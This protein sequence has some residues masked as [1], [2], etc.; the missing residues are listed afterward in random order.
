MASQHSGT[1]PDGID[2]FPEKIDIFIDGIDSFPDDIDT[3]P[4]RLNSFP[5]LLDCASV[6]NRLQ[7]NLEAIYAFN[8]HSLSLFGSVARNEATADSDLDFLVEFEGP[9]TFRGYMGLKFYLENLF[10]KPVDLVI[11]KDLKERIKQSVIE[12]AIRVA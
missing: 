2:A 4:K 9:A 11:K 12:E 10:G 6:R 1:F 3:F 7:Q 5:E 8:V